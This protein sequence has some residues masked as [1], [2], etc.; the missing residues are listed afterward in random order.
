MA[1]TATSSR[2]ENLRTPLFYL[3]EGKVKLAVTSKQ[4]K[5]AI[6]AILGEGDF[7][8]EGCLAGQRLRMATAYDDNRLFA[9]QD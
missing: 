4:G 2:K 3:R 9:G 1:R 5:E 8:G 6:V 7:F